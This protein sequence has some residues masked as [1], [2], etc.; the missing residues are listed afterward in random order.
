[1]FE[2]NYT[3][4]ASFVEYLRSQTADKYWEQ[5]DTDKTDALNENVLKLIV[6]VV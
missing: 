2:L 6:R 1:M 4:V 5:C 3:R